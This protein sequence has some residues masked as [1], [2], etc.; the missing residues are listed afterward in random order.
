MIR[1][2]SHREKSCRLGKEKKSMEFVKRKLE[3][4]SQGDEFQL[5]IL[6]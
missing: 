2:F 4:L 3:V 6:E 1:L 5:F